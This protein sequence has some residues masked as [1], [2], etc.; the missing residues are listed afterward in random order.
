MC[1]GACAC[2]CLSC[3]C[4]CASCVGSRVTHRPC[5]LV[6]VA[7]AA[8]YI[9]RLYG[10]RSARGAGAQ[11][12]GTHAAHTASY[13]PHC[14]WQRCPCAFA[15]SCTQVMNSEALFKDLLAQTQARLL[16]ESMLVS[17]TGCQAVRVCLGLS[18]QVSHDISGCC[19]TPAHAYTLTHI[20]THSHIP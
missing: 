9:Q 4:V 7:F 19:I 2:S 16:R 15:R 11:A 13:N 12:P 10:A 8:G 5:W 17:V 20:H 3:A 1:L 6:S 18:E 14:T